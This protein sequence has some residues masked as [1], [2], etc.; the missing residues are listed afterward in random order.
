MKA[1][2][3]IPSTDCPPHNR[4]YRKRKRYSGFGRASGGWSPLS[5]EKDQAIRKCSSFLPAFNCVRTQCGCFPRPD[6]FWV[7]FLGF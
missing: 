2:P 6:H 5:G 3:P 4:K 1:I 7:G